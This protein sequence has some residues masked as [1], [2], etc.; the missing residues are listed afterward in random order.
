MVLFS[1]VICQVIHQHN[2]YGNLEMW[3]IYST[4][5]SYTYNASGTYT[6]TLQATNSLGSDTETKN[7]YITVEFPG[8]TSVTNGESCINTP[9]LLSATNGSGDL[10][11]YDSTGLVFVGD[12]FVTPPLSSA[13]SYTVK[14][15]IDRPSVQAGPS[16]NNFGTGGYHGSGFY[17]A[18]NFT[19]DTNF[20]ILSV[21]VDADGAGDRVVY[22][23]DGNIA[24]GGAAPANTVLQQVTV[25]LVDGPQRVNLNINVPSSGDYSLGGN[26]MDLYRNNSGPVYPY[27]TPGILSMTSSTA[28]NA[29]GFII[30]SV[31]GDW[32]S[33]L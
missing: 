11:W 29:Q 31:I 30:I 16:D 1:L 3:C 33:A 32:Y 4:N 24:N 14:D 8:I 20:T 10:H 13:Q 23:W 15:V 9:V 27:V 21:W 6:V 12:T 22:L 28:N 19:A 26:Q 2:G 25:T 18:V 17:G 5:P 7:L